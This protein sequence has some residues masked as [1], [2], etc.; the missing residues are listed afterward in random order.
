MV[1]EVF[2][3]LSIWFEMD[4]KGD[5]MT[6]SN[7]GGG[8]LLPELSMNKSLEQPSCLYTFQCVNAPVSKSPKAYKLPM[9]TVSP[10]RLCN[11]RKPNAQAFLTYQNKL[12]TPNLSDV[13]H[14]QTLKY[15]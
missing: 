3:Y 2:N 4:R 10:H 9:H 11:R 5:R 15:I 6:N 12:V 1:A 13:D 8:E 7:P 14:S